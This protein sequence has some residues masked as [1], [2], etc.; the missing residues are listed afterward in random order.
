MTDKIID[1]FI[2]FEALFLRKE[3]MQELSYSFSLRGA[4]FLGKNEEERKKTLNK[5]KERDKLSKKMFEEVGITKGERV[6]IM[7]YDFKPFNPKQPTLGIWEGC[8]A[9]DPYV[10]VIVYGNNK[11]TF[12]I[13]EEYTG[14]A[15]CMQVID[16]DHKYMSPLNYRLV[17]ESKSVEEWDEEDT[18]DSFAE[19]ELIIYHEKKEDITSI[20]EKRFELDK[21][22]EESSEKKSLRTI[23]GDIVDSSSRDDTETADV[24]FLYILGPRGVAI[25]HEEWMKLTKHGCGMCAK[26]ISPEESEEMEWW[27]ENKDSPVC[28]SCISDCHNNAKKNYGDLH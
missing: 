24:D 7:L 23:S 25:S 19:R 10:T 11:D 1:Y 27:G 26:D 13:G 17:I 28:P 3:E 8:T 2:A 5:L 20:R 18:E 12:V 9:T 4:H 16:P 6:R 22:K 14:D 15:L 21:S